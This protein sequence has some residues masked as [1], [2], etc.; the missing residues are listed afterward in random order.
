MRG[1]AFQTPTRNG[2]PKPFRR[3]DTSSNRATGGVGLGLTIARQSLAEQGGT[4]TWANRPS[5]GLLA[6]IGLP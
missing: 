4:L 5:G 6:S 3:L 1:R 2:C